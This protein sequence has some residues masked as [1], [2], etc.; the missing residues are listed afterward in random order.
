MTTRDALLTKAVEKLN[1]TLD[2]IVS[3]GGLVDQ[4]KEGAS[5]LLKALGL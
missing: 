5:N 2:D 1:T 3:A 4:A